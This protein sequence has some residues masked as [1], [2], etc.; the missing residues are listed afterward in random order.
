MKK[1][2]A[3]YPQ[4]YGGAEPKTKKAARW[5]AFSKRSIETD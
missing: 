4:T 1:R 3:L 2:R 5:A